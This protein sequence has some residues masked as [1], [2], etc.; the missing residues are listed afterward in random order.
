MTLHEQPESLS[1]SA[2]AG[3]ATAIMR[4]EGATDI[5]AQVANPLPA[6][7]PTDLPEPEL[8]ANA[9]TVLERRYLK[10][11]LETGEVIETPRELFWRVATHVAQ[12]ELAFEGGSPE[13]A[14]SIA[15]DFYGLMAERVFMP[16]H[17]SFR[18]GHE[19]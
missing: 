7:P 17:V 18:T 10:K 8:T 6:I 1:F 9:V 12:A 19:G 13:L 2:P 11:S 14:L 4:T 16:W 3:A 15:R 5:G